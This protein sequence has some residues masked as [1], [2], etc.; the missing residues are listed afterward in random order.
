MGIAELELVHHYSTSTCYTLSRHPVLQTVW[1]INV[2]QVAFASNFA[3]HALLAISALH[4]AYLKPGQKELYI[5]QALHHHDTALRA[6]TSILPNMTKDNCCGLYLLSAMN[7]IISC[8]KPRR[9][10]DFLLTGEG[11]ISDWLTSFR[12]IRTI[13]GHARDQLI[14]SPLAPMFTIG[15]RKIYLREKRF[16][17]PQTYVL[18]LRRNIEEAV[19]DHMTRQIYL[20][21]LDELSKSFGMV[22]D[23]DTQSCESADIFAWLFLISEDY[24]RLL[25]ER[26]PESL[27]IFGYYC[28]ILKQLEWAWWMEGRS[29]YLIADIYR[30]LDEEHKLVRIP[31]EQFLPIS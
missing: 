7:C 12:G 16:T 21:S 9:P 5:S 29:A 24:L 30:L 4:L 11:W 6:A 17:A 3:I 10:G 14:A 15:D 31:G 23:G 28:V 20:D 8:A 2:P 25:D 22:L 18:E 13:I 27:I 1:R 19:S 26:T